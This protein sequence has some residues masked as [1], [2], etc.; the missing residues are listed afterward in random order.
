M[1]QLEVLHV[2]RDSSA[3]LSEATSFACRSLH[4]YSNNHEKQQDVQG[5]GTLLDLGLG[6]GSPRKADTRM[7][8]IVD[9]GMNKLNKANKPR[10][11][12]DEPDGYALLTYHNIAK[13]SV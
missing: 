3:P 12:V 10:F 7:S 13:D 4:S 8:A 11:Q 6:L 1:L 5:V 2:V 9:G